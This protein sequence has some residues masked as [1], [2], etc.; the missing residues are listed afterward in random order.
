MKPQRQRFCGFDFESQLPMH[1]TLNS[2]LSEIP[3]DPPSPWPPPTPPTEPQPAPVT[4]PPAE[5]KP[6]GPFT[7]M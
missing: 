6:K 2:P 5:P 7:V 1:T 4:D 3:D